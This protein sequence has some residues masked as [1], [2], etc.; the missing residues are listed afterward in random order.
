MGSYFSKNDDDKLPYI[1]QAELKKERAKSESLYYN[2]KFG[3]QK[4]TLHVDVID[5]VNLMFSDSFKYEKIKFIIEYVK[6]HKLLHQID[7][8]KLDYLM[9]L[10]NSHNCLKTAIIKIL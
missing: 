6:K 1:S 7:K 5:Y 10:N 9:A 2:E 8:E 4:N 3:T